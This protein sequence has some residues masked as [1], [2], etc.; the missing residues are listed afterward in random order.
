[1]K[2][3]E[4]EELINGKCP[5]IFQYI[6][7]NEQACIVV[8]DQTKQLT[9]FYFGIKTPYESMPL[10]TPIIQTDSADEEIEMN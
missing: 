2:F 9:N 10:T 7:M 3:I 5:L 1:M 8:C 6:L 4:K